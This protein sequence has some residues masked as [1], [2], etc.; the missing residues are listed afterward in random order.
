MNF[1]GVKHAFARNDDL[2]RLLFDWHGPHQCSHFFCGFPLGK[3]PQS[4]LPCPNASVDD[5][6]KQLPSS[7]IEN[8]NSSVYGLRGKVTLKSL[9]D[10]NPIYICIIHKPDDLV[11]EEIAV[12]LAA[13]VWLCRFRRVQLQP[14]PNSFSQNVQSRVC[15]HDLLHG[16]DHKRLHS[17]KPISISRVVIVGQIN[18]NHC[19]MRCGVD[20][21]V[22]RG[23]VQKLGPHIP[24]NIMRIKITPSQLNI[25][26]VLVSSLLIKGIVWLSK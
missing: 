3:L 2:F 20:G 9:V 16:L 5:F 24:L 26:P 25:Q 6:Q 8:K 13:Q 10:G 17:W 12:V 18:S 19:A 23:V 1:Q 4:L 11:A 7:W 14:L 22:I 21:H 15:L